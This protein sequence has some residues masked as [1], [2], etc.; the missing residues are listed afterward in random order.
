MEA[1]AF[2]GKQITMYSQRDPSTDQIYIAACY[3]IVN[4]SGFQM[5]VVDPEQVEIKK[6]QSDRVDKKFKSLAR[7]TI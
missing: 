5:P 4:Y 7:I 2:K 6:V 3:E 1:N